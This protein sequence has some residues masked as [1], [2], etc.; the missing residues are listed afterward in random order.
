MPL[1]LLA[2]GYFK[3]HSKTFKPVL[4][5][6]GFGLRS[7]SSSSSSPFSFLTFANSP[8]KVFTSFPSA[9]NISIFKSFLVESK[10]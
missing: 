9:S 7:S 1:K 4:I 3:S 6:G 2:A 8:T 5:V 10:K